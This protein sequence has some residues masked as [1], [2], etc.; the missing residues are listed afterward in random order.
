MPYIGKQ[1]KS[2]S[3]NIPVGTLEEL[4]V[5]AKQFGV[6]V[7]KDKPSLF[8]RGLDIISR[9]LYAS[10]GA[11]KAI[12]KK[13]N[14]LEET[15]KG[16]SG[17]EKETYSD[18]L[19]EV[20]VENKWVRG[21]VGFALDVALDPTT[22]FGGTLVKGALKGVGAV[23]RTGLKTYS[24]FSPKS[25]AS[26]ESAGKS[27]K[28]AFG[29]AFKFGYGTTAGVSDDVARYWNRLGIE[30]EAIS[31]K[32]FKI[33]G[34]YNND[35]LKEASDLMLK[36]KKIELGIREGGEGT[37]IKG[38]GKTAEA[39]DDMKTIALSIGKKTGIPEEQLYKN[40]FPSIST[41]QARMAKE[42]PG[43]IR[44]GQ[45][46]YLKKFQDKLKDII[47]KPIEAYSRREFEV[48]R[49]LITR[50][51][52]NDIVTGYGKSIKAFDKLDD[53]SKAL[54]KPIYEK[55]RPELQL[56][57]IK[58]EP[59]KDLM[60][61]ITANKEP[62]ER[63]MIKVGKGIQD[64]ISEGVPVTAT[65]KL[66]TASGVYHKGENAIKLKYFTPE[67]LLHERGHSW[68]F[69]NESLS[70]VINT[71]KVFQKE[72]RTLTDKFY[73]GTTQQ[74]GSAVEKWAVFIDNFIHNPEFVK[75]NAPTFTGY[76]RQKLAKDWKFKKAYQ[77]ASK[78]IKVIDK[79]VKNI[80]PA[81]QKADKG[82][83]KTAV[84]TAFPSKE[85]IG[86]GGFKKP[87]GYLKEGDFNFINNHMFPEMKTIDMLAKATGY[88]GF[89]RMFK[90]A[91]T[92]YFPA[93]HVRNYI[94]GNVQNYS[95]LG[96][97]AF[98][99]VNHKNALGFL[100][101][102]N[103]V[104][105]FKNWSGTGDD[106]NKILK[107]NFRGASRYI[108]DL[109][110][111]I[112]DLGGKGFKVRKS[113]SKLNPR[114]LGNFIEMNQ[115]AVAVSGALKQGKT[116]KEAIKLA[117]KAG[118]DYTKITQFE[119]K[120]MRR[121]VPFYTFARKNAEL[122]LRTATKNPERILN[123]IKFTQNL[124]EIFGGGKPTEEDLQG[125]PPWALSGL[126]FK[127]EG[128]RYLTKFGLPL[129]E[130]VERINKPLMTTLSSANPLIKYPLE[131]KMGYDFFREQK[132][133]DIN[134][135]SPVSGKLI[136]EKAPE[137][138][139]EIFNVK[140]VVSKHDGK[141]RYYASPT[142][143]H[144]LRNIPTAR[145]QNTLEKLLE[146]DK[147]S[148]DKWLAFISGAKIYDIDIDMQKYFKEK[149]LRED[150]ERDMMQ[151]GIG[152]ESRAFY[153]LKNQ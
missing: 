42:M 63:A 151:K 145:F 2:T 24:K 74:R 35:T 33:L 54:W 137:W 119:S 55:G 118:F 40:Y 11:A 128:N 61:Q 110:N 82:F 48:T 125:L 88:D 138:M 72:L 86:F 108:S 58:Y 103:K 149:D 140:E 36:N 146:N 152:R 6:K 132:I 10:A 126:G 27:L 17:K 78:Q 66:R 99:P 141:T 43:G 46:G 4:E 143:L 112:E 89:T 8:R 73:G 49:N 12:I 56:Y 69:M 77:E 64:A 68:D 144:R 21:G 85:A 16:L 81:I 71:K 76:F 79:T 109:G 53:A 97:Q 50:E 94:S 70:K 39:M 135:I 29:H 116:I 133:M 98:N 87:L 117:E 31:E 101:G 93:F 60:Q 51:T 111:Y 3:K 59:A 153:I 52:L 22:Y 113:I 142:M 62:F 104:I 107:E 7:K 5:A 41:Q 147:E 19:K 130:F 34:K 20:G 80:K 83:L 14:I 25:A 106:M 123:Q 92:A 32:N 124:S 114:Q 26:L 120:I 148:V 95:V 90:T 129:E 28:D 65:K 134:K 136:K 84:E 105:K 122:Q 37:F 150:I 57:K 18:V 75:K 67:V 45:E 47:N 91:V 15:W 127:V 96:S 44:V 1:S 121:A 30:K 115:K 100:K 131:S 23:G 38:T 102:S 9:P 13:E 139:Q